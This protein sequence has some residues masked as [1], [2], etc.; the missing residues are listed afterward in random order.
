MPTTALQPYHG[1]YLMPSVEH[2]S[3]ADAMRPG[4]MACEPDA[5][6]TE[7]ARMM[8]GHHVHCL[9]VMG[10]SQQEPESLVWGIITDLDL[11]GAGLRA[12]AE[13]TARALA[14]HPM[15]TIDSRASLREAGELMLEKG[16]THLVVTDIERMLPV[17][18]LSTLDIAGVLGW[19]EA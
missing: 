4:I 6:L 5:T 12:G 18:I 16:V 13:P 15:L 8:A 17:G 1:S 2:A 19:G 3:V 7:V 10:I 9:A 14:R 11:L